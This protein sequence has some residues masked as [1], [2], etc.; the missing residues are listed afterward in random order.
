MVLIG[1]AERAI[2]RKEWAEA[3]ETIEKIH[4][5]GFRTSLSQ[6]LLGLALLRLHRWDEAVEQYESIEK[7]VFDP[8]HNSWRLLNHS[9]ALYEVG[10][11]DECAE[12]LRT[13]IDDTWA[14]EPLKRAK[15]LLAEF[16]EEQ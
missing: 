9:I 4:R 7:P 13:S 5:R 10:R 1:R 11:K 16:Q 14:E 6:H 2:H 8:A 3:A 12:L 15:A